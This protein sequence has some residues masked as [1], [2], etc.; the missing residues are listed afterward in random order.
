MPHEPLAISAR[1]GMGPL[2]TGTIFGRQESQLSDA[3]ADRALATFDTIT[4]PRLYSRRRRLFGS[5]WSLV[6]RRYEHLWPFCNAWSA[7][8]TLATLG[9]DRRPAQFLPSFLQGLAAYSRQGSASRIQT[10]EAY[11]EASV[12]RHESGGG[13]IFFDDNAWLG[14]SLVRQF[15][16]MGDP[17]AGQLATRVLRFLTS[18]WSKSGDWKSPGGIPW[19]SSGGALSRN[20]CSNAPAA[21]LA[22]R[23]FMHT[24]DASHLRWATQIYDWV[25]ASLFDPG[26]H[27]YFDRIS[28]EGTVEETYWS[29]NQGSMIGAGVLLYRSTGEASYLVEAQETASGAVRMFTLEGLVEQGPAFNA[30]LFRNLFMLG[31]HAPDARYRATAAS[32]GDLMWDTRRNH[33]DGTFQSGASVLNSTAPMIEIYALLAGGTPKA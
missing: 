22:T 28:P 12:V 20:T 18:G 27:L 16:L 13:D 26:T 8:T 21:E 4:H 19:T 7:T 33:A 5:R 11:F 30:I 29:Y 15:E 1:L 25:R 23:V 6:L 3:A 24:N 32:Y 14:L 9:R 2:Q 31:Q 17:R 10:G